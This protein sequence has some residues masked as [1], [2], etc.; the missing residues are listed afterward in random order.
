MKT[1]E[2]ALQVNLAEPASDQN[3]EDLLQDRGTGFVL[4]RLLSYRDSFGEDDAR[5]QPQTPQSLIPGSPAAKLDADINDM[6]QQLD[7][8]EAEAAA[9]DAERLQASNAA[10][11]AAGSQDLKRITEGSVLVESDG[12]QEA[13][14]DGPNTLQW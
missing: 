14:N 11:A 1:G 10:A 8:E 9:E 4:H 3:V 6:L 7:A 5:E 12:E 13:F 2:G